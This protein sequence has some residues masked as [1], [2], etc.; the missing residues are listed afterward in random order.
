MGVATSTEALSREKQLIFNQ[1]IWNSER[2]VEKNRQFVNQ[3][4]KGKEELKINSIEK[5]HRFLLKKIEERNN[6]HRKKLE[7]ETQNNKKILSDDKY[8]KAYINKILS[9]KSSKS[10]EPINR[11]FMT[12]Q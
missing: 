12:N 5:Q 9:N 8:F 1:Q 4:R 7:I 10:L 6:E 3:L 11:R 2:K